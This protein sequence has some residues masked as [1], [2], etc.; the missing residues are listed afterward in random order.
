MGLFDMFKKKEKTVGRKEGE[1]RF[2][3]RNS[4][5]NGLRKKKRIQ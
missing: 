1:G 5:R 3:R 2:G 4:R